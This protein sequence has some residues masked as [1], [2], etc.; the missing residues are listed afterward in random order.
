MRSEEPAATGSTRNLNS[1]GSSLHLRSVE[2]GELH[3]SNRCAWCGSWASSSTLRNVIF[4]W[5]AAP[6]AMCVDRAGC[7]RRRQIANR[8]VA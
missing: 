8:W 7:A 5:T 2:V 1:T 4:V 6:G 3:P